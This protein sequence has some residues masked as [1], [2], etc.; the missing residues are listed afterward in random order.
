[1]VKTINIYIYTSSFRK[2]P[3]YYIKY[4]NSNTATRQAK[5]VTVK[6]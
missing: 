1:M 2:I 3:L 6:L 4:N 5:I